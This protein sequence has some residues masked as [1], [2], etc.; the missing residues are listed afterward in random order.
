MNNKATRLAGILMGGIDA[1]LSRAVGADSL[2]EVERAILEPLMTKHLGHMQTEMAEELVTIY[3]DS[4]ASIA[5][6]YATEA[7]RVTIEKAPDFA[8]VYSDLFNQM[9]RAVTTEMD[10]AINNAAEAKID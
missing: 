1:S 8:Q 7:G 9:M 4:V 6:F 10:L 3:G 5:D 2:P